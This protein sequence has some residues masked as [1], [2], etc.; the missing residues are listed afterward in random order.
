MGQFERI[1][2]YAYRAGA[3]GY[4]AGRAIW[5]PAFQALPDLAR[6]KAMLDSDALEY[7]N[8]INCLTD[9]EA[10]SWTAAGYFR[11][12]LRLSSGG[13]HFPSDYRS[14]LDA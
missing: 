5:W 9:K 6:M 4:L 3:N 2:T 12:G 14:D 13:E 7:Q 11:D 10:R 8:R 1:L